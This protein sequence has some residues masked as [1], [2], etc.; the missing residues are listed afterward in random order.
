V[1]RISRTWMLRREQF[2]NIS[3]DG[4]VDEELVRQARPS[5]TTVM[6][7]CEFE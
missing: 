4:Y 7:C 6:A 1:R 5:P 3:T 2:D